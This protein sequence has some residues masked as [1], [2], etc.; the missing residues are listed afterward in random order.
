MGIF[1]T[2]ATQRFHALMLLGQHEICL[3]YSCPTSVAC[4][5]RA[6]VSPGS[7]VRWVAMRLFLVGVM[8]FSLGAGA[9]LAQTGTAAQPAAAILPIRQP[10]SLP[11]SRQEKHTSD[12]ADCIQMWDTGTH[13]TKRE[14]AATCKRVQTHLENIKVDAMMP[15]RKTKMR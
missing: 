11:Q 8:T 9:S 5:R 10:P 1:R 2:L 15:K 3:A 13:M 7:G 4:L 14:W 12:V 6:A